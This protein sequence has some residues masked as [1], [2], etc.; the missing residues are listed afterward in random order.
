KDSQWNTLDGDWVPL[1]WPYREV[2]FQLA[3]SLPGESPSNWINCFEGYLGDDI[4]IEGHQLK[5]SARDKSKRLQDAYIAEK[6]TYDFSNGCAAEDL[7]QTIIDDFV[8][9]PPTLCC[10]VPSGITFDR[11]EVEYVSVWDAIQNIARQMG[12]FLGYMWN[13]TEFALSFIEPPRG[14]TTSDL[15][16]VLFVIYHVSLYIT[17]ADIRNLLVLTY[18]DKN[19]GERRTL[20][21][22]D[23]PQLRNDTSKNEFGGQY[24]IMEIEE[25]DTSLI[26]TEEK[27]L[28]FGAKCIWDLSELSATDKLD[29]PLLPE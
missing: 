18:R 24:R 28:A 16:I 4:Q 15:D 25:A 29:L 26:D 5:I 23:Y 10:P 19:T 9:N 2:V 8:D 11:M 22:K 21:Y 20:S 6:K 17:Y 7:I 27:A 1:L 14:K 13:G 3:T 12:W